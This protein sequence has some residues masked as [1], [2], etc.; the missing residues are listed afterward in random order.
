MRAVRSALRVA[1]DGRTRAIRVRY[2]EAYQSIS[3]RSCCRSVVCRR[4]S[5]QLLREELL[6]RSTIVHRSPRTNSGPAQVGAEQGY[7]FGLERLG[8]HWIRGGQ[9]SMDK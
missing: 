2:V 1:S 6:P 3:Q 8:S 9:E 7:H 4:V 5:R